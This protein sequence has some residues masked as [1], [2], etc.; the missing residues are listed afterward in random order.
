MD[1]Q[2]L[3][4][5]CSFVSYVNMSNTRSLRS[6]SYL[7]KHGSL[8][9]K[10]TLWWLASSVLEKAKCVLPPELPFFVAKEWSVCCKGRTWG[11]IHRQKDAP[12]LSGVVQS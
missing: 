3:T 8:C 6:V 2:T 4:I 7:F 5:K 12:S 11:G 10:V 9:S 1:A